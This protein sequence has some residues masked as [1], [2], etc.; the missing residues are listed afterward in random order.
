MF[1]MFT[2]I[3]LYKWDYTTLKIKNFSHKTLLELCV[4]KR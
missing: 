1:Y 4:E 3:V 2:A